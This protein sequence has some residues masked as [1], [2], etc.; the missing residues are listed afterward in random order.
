MSQTKL[1]A[2]DL[3]DIHSNV[4]DNN[5][6]LRAFGALLQD[7]SF[8]DFND[9]TGFPESANKYRLGLRQIIE[10]CI[11]HQESILNEIEIKIKNTDIDFLTKK[12]KSA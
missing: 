7:S 10:F 1:S 5:W 3:I 8:Q 4:I 11:D 2:I 12:T 9:E 6:S